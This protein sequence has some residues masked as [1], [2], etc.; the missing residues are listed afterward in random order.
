MLEGDWN[1]VAGGMFDDVY[2]QEI[3]EISPF[4]IPSSWRI[5]RSFDWG[6]SKPFSVGWWA[7]SDG[8]EATLP[9]DS[10]KAWPRG[11]LFRIGEWYG[12]SGQPNEGCKMLAVEVAKGILDRELSAPWG[13]RVEP[14]PADNSIFDAEN[15]VCIADDMAKLGIRWERS[16]KSPGSR[17]TGWEAMRRMFKACRKH[18]MEEP[19]LYVFNTCRDGFIRTV[20]ALIRDQNKT[21]DVD[22]NA[23][24]HCGDEARYRCLA[25]KRFAFSQEFR[26]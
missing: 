15:G 18:P 1:I 20:P 2:S 4:N 25:V 3:H 24:D 19:G 26:L 16:D 7:E 23:E 5:D 9:D 14:G 10:K 12:W 22:T 17:K 8:T 6:S 21:D 11:T 13:S